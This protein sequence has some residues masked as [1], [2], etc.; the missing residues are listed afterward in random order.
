MLI[1]ARGFQASI[2]AFSGESQ[3]KLVPRFIADLLRERR[4]YRL[5]RSRR[6]LSFLSESVGTGRSA[7][8]FL[9][10]RRARRKEAAILEGLAGLSEGGASRIPGTTP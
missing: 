4:A 5:F 3:K 1:G 8:H 10:V 6:L 7:V 2:Q 9:S